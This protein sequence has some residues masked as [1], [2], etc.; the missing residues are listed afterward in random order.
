[1]FLV[2]GDLCSD[3]LFD[4]SFAPFISTHRPTRNKKTGTLSLNVYQTALH[5]GER[6]EFALALEKEHDNDFSRDKREKVRFHQGILEVIS[7]LN[8]MR[9]PVVA[10]AVQGLSMNH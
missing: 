10:Q 8:T 3:L 9:T 6:M 4:Q 1:M 5:Q 2:F 7:F